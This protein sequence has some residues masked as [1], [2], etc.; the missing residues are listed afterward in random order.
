MGSCYITQ[1]AQP[2]AL[3]W[4]RGVGWG[5]GREAQEGGEACI[6]YGRSALLYGI[7]SHNVIKHIFLQYKKLKKKRISKSYWEE[8][9]AEF[10]DFLLGHLIFQDVTTANPQIYEQESSGGCPHLPKSSPCGRLIYLKL[11]IADGKST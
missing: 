8:E 3:W 7:N 9:E 10:L 11:F 6:N 5:G 4:P 1:G 2:A